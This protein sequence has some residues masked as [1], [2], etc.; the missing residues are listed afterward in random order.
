MIDIR[1]NYEIKNETTFKIGGCVRKAAFPK[2]REELISLLQTGEYEIILGNCSNVLFSSDNIDKNIIL[3]KETKNFTFDDDF[4][5]VECGARGPFLSRECQKRGLSGFEF[6]IGFPGSFGGMVCMN[7]SAHNQAVSDK[8]V[9]ATVYDKTTGKVCEFSKSDM[10]FSY[11]K[12]VLSSG[13]YVLLDAKFKLEKAPVEDITDLTERNI[14]FRKDHQPSL[15]YGNAGSVF[16][17]PPGDSAGRL[18][19]LCNMKGRKTGGA[20]VFQKHANFILNMDN[21]TSFDVIKLMYEMYSAVKE[22]YRIE[23]TPEIIYIGNEET[24]ENKLWQEMTKENMQT[25]L[26]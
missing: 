3:T 11:R 7:A 9:S 4:L 12:S 20:E 10:A 16:K 13:N 24:E 15:T 25:T 17:N 21:A 23:L 1:E 8:F 26:K 19:D 5:K 6:L 14:K 2:N 18:L 22:N